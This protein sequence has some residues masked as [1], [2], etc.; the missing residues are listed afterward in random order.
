MA[1]PVFLAAPLAIPVAQANHLP[2]PI[3]II[4]LIPFD[5]L[6][7]PVPT[8]FHPDGVAKQADFNGDGRTDL[9]VQAANGSGTSYLFLANANNKYTAIAQSWNASYLGLNWGADASVA[10]KARKFARKPDTGGPHEVGS[11]SGIWRQRYDE[12]TWTLS[13]ERSGSD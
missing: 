13:D 7:I 6:L 3:T 4:N 10:T 11:M 5:D 8:P 1:C 9:L 12:A 2:A